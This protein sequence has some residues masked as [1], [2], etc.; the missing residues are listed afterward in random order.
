LRLAREPSGVASAPA[1]PARGNRAPA[2]FSVST[3]ERLLTSRFR[4]HAANVFRQFLDA[5][6]RRLLT[7]RPAR[8]L[9]GAQAHAQI[10]FCISHRQGHVELFSIELESRIA[11]IGNTPSSSLRSSNAY[12]SIGILRWRTNVRSI[13]ELQLISASRHDVVDTPA[14]RQTQ[15]AV[16]RETGVS[17][18]VFDTDWR[19]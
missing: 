6:R 2:R 10:P 16:D 15:S 17:R 8:L 7:Q 14:A 9:E 3:N 5:R 13:S 1:V 4:R 12:C 18:A 11:Q 19:V